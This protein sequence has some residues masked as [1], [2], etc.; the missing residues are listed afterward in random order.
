[1]HFLCTFYPDLVFGSHGQPGKEWQ[2]ALSRSPFFVLWNGS[3]AVYVFFVLSGF[4][5]AASARNTRVALPLLVGRRYLRLTLPAL[6]STLLAYLLLMGFPDVTQRLA[7]DT[8]NGWLIDY[9]YRDLTAF[10]AVIDA[11][12]NPY[13]FG[14]SYANSVLW[15]MRY[16]L[17]GSLSIY[18]IYRFCPEQWRTLF[19]VSI[20]ILLIPQGTF[21][22]NFLGFAAGAL[23]QEMHLR[24]VFQASR[25]KLA[26]VSCAIGLG[27]GALP[28]QSAEQSYFYPLVEL[29]EH[30]SAPAEFIYGLGAILLM[31]GCLSSGEI[32]TYLEIPVFRFLGRISFGIYLVHFPILALPFIGLYL[33]WLPL[34]SGSG[35][36]FFTLLYF[37]MVGGLAYVF[38]TFIDEPVIVNL[39]RV[40][41]NQRWRKAKVFFASHALVLTLLI[42]FVMSR[43]GPDMAAVLVWSVAYLGFVV[44]TM[45]LFDIVIPSR[46]VAPS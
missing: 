23:I 15:T 34:Q 36:L 29:V 37:V 44:V 4:V 33:D 9:Y 32:L 25:P 16:E 21:L 11:V 38:T 18:L 27:L 46:A 20:L 10:Y 17:Y 24:G 43:L 40:Q 45:R 39:K 8:Q 6:A 2:D 3:F 41:F 35:F 5:I 31:L 30:F 1:M 19:L 22:V 28:Q 14:E 26:V 13:R 42:A 7:T 12:F